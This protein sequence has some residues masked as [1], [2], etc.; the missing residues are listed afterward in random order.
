V[1]QESLRVGRELLDAV[2]HRDPLGA[3]G[4]TD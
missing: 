3:L 1:S 4:E 2:E